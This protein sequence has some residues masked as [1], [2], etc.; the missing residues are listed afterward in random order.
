M[1]VR[2]NWTST[3]ISGDRVFWTV[4][5]DVGRTLADSNAV[6]LG[7]YGAENSR[8]VYISNPNGVDAVVT[9]VAWRAGEWHHLMACWDETLGY[10]ALYIDGMFC[11]LRRYE[12]N[13]PNAPTAF[14]IGYVPGL[15]WG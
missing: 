10:R 12:R 15:R 8:I 1:W 2:P 4:D 14:H 11:G 13:M 3:A 7:F 9:P 5:R 6:Y